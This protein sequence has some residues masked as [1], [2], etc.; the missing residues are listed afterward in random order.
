MQHPKAEATRKA[1]AMIEAKRVDRDPSSE[2]PNDGGPGGAGSC[3]LP[4]EPSSD[5]GS[6]AER[7]AAAST[8]AAVV[9]TRARLVASKE[10]KR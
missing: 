7:V 9:A 4:E 5:R 6:R 2:A 1:V 8:S 10:T 3:P